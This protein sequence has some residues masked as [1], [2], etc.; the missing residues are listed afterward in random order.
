MVAATSGSGAPSISASATRG[1]KN[2]GG[3]RGLRVSWGRRSPGVPAAHR[4]RLPAPCSA[5]PGYTTGAGRKGPGG[6]SRGFPLGKGRRYH[7]GAG[8]GALGNTTQNT[9]FLRMVCRRSLSSARLV[10]V[11]NSLGRLFQGPTTLSER[12]PFP[13]VQPEFPLAELHS[14]SSCAA[15]GR[16]GEKSSTS[17]PLPPV[18]KTSQV[19]SASYILAS[20]PFIM[21]PPY[22]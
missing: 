6:D 15:A 3:E 7:R 5:C 16:E 19:T 11:T 2:H 20:M 21:W 9:R 12:E 8:I 4:P 14:V 18:R 22:S 13:D 17:R 1:E 10:A